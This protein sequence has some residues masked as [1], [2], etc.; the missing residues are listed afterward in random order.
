MSRRR[1]HVATLAFAMLVVSGIVQA[2][3]AVTPPT[4]QFLVA[5]AQGDTV[6]Y[7][8][9]IFWMGTDAD[10]TVPYYRYLID[11]DPLFPYWIE[12]DRS[13]QVFFFRATD[14]VEPI[15]PTGPIRSTSEHT[16]AVKAVDNDGNESAVV[17]RTF[18]A[19][20][21]APEVQITSPVPSPGNLLGPGVVLPS[22]S[23]TIQWQGTDWD[24][25][26]TDRPV[27]YKRRLFTD[28]SLDYNLVYYLAYPDSLRKLF[29]PGF[30]NWDSTS[31]D[32]TSVRYWGLNP[33]QEYLFVV[34]GFDEAGAY[35]PRFGTTINMLWF[36]AGYPV[37]VEDLMSVSDAGAIMP[38]KSTW[39]EPKLRDGLLIHLI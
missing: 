5:P 9:H 35:S 15:P 28:Y 14:P 27:K 8:Q 10:G 33:Q 31:S 7:A 36:R 2:A 11:P 23:V 18:R 39:F 6:H 34:V 16:F 22:N 30:V 12:T 29:A 19:F 32:T 38:P 20:T 4:I 24:G 37:S 3:H 17:S 1:P 25:S 26:F 21:I 13:H